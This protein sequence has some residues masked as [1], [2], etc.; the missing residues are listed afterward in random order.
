MG[1]RLLNCASIFPACTLGEDRWFTENGGC[2]LI[3]GSACFFKKAQELSDK[4]TTKTETIFIMETDLDKNILSS[5][6]RIKNKKAQPGRLRFQTPGGLYCFTGNR[7]L[8][9]I[10]S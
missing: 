8:R 4:K 10:R 3:T 2:L 1:N 6:F 9:Q 7:L 5:L